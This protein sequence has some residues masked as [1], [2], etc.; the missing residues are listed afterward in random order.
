MQKRPHIVL[1]G[2]M[3]SGKSH[4]G[5]LLAARLG[6]AFVDVDARIERDAG[7]PIPAI[8]SDEGE[9]GFRARES[10]LLASALLAETAVIAS[11]GGAIL[12]EA[13]RRAMRTHGRVVYLHVDAD[14]QLRRLA[15]DTSRPLLAVPDRAARLAQLQA[16]REPLYRGSADIV[17]ET[18]GQSPEQVAALLAAMLQPEEQGA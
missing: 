13:N 4:V 17:L 16:V 12:A 6:L 1:V 3:G 10:R 11:G 14:E 8:F 2:P 7:K 18:S 9:A 15:D 5:Q